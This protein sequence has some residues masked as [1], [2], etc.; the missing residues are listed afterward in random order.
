MVGSLASVGE[1]VTRDCVFAT[2]SLV[3]TAVFPETKNIQ[4]WCSGCPQL[5]LEG[6]DLKNGFMKLE[7][8]M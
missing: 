5:E 3:K 2:S 1:D 6:L 8:L 4:L 7:G